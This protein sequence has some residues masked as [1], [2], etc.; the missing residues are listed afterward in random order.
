LSLHRRTLRLR[1][2]NSTKK[3]S[4]PI[5]LPSLSSEEVRKN[6]HLVY[7]LNKEKVEGLYIQAYSIKTRQIQETS[8]DKNGEYRLKGLVPGQ[9][10]EIRVKIPGNSSNYYKLK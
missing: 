3:R 6:V 8:I 2:V 7:N 10:Y 5:E 9:E 4:L 1:V